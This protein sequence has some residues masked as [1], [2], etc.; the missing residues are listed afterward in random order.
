M[1]YN[2]RILKEELIMW[3]YIKGVFTVIGIF[4]LFIAGAVWQEKQHRRPRRNE[5]VSYSEYLRTR[6]RA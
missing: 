5:C 6:K 3:N 1:A 4:S 2:E